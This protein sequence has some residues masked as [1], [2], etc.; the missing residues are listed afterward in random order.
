MT[1]SSPTTRRPSTSPTTDRPRPSG[2]TIAVT[3]AGV[4]TDVDVVLSGVGHDNP[5]DIDVLLVG[6][7]GR[8]VTLDE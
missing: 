4:I 1:T 8:Q 6:P 3:H 5:D 7:W 2:S